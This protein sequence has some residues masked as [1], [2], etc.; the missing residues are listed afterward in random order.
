M[1]K[2]TRL[3]FLDRTLTAHDLTNAAD[4]WRL[5]FEQDRCISHDAAGR[6]FA[7]CEVEVYGFAVDER[8]ALAAAALQACERTGCSVALDASC[9]R[10]TLCFVG[11]WTDAH[12]ARSIEDPPDALWH[13]LLGAPALDGLC[14]SLTISCRAGLDPARCERGFGGDLTLFGVCRGRDEFLVK[15]ITRRDREPRM[16]FIARGMTSPLEQHFLEACDAFAR[17]RPVRVGAAVGSCAGPIALGPEWAH[18]RAAAVAVPV[19][20]DD[21]TAAAGAR[22]LLPVAESKQHLFS[23][24]SVDRKAARIVSLVSHVPGERGLA[25]FVRRLLGCVTLV[26]SLLYFA[27]AVAYTPVQRFAAF[28]GAPLFLALGSR[29]VLVKFRRAALYRKLWRAGFTKLYSVEGGAKAANWEPLADDPHPHR[30]RA[31]WE[32]IGARYCFDFALLGAEQASG[33]RSASQCFV[34]DS[35]WTKVVVMY[36]YGTKNQM[37]FPCNVLFNLKTRFADGLRVVTS[38][39]LAGSYRKPVNPK[40][41]AR[42]AAGVTDP[43]AMLERH[44]EVVRRLI[45]EGHRPVPPADD[46]ASH[47]AEIKDDH[48]EASALRR[49][50]THGTWADA[51]RHTFELPCRDY[52]EPGWPRSAPEGS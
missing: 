21:L 33:A 9:G 19:A 3:A 8:D 44:R 37:S 15:T 17:G 28:A 50:M 18:L 46:F 26:A 2:F 49:G 36:H 34:L 35:D 47:A 13:G 22:R 43:A 16:R 40:V 32:A 10:D 23:T 48:A 41:I 14:L 51:L 38:N 45:D 1:L 31:E 5:W 42:V 12:P 25:R 6:G 52:F 20:P 27:I 30:F 29:I 39:Q 7:R 11:P 4:L 24:A